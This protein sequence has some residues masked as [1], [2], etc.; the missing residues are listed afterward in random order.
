M[1]SLFLLWIV[2]HVYYFE[3][4]HIRCIES[5][6]QLSTIRIG[7][8]YMYMLMMDMDVPVANITSF[9]PKELCMWW[10]PVRQIYVRVF[11]RP[12]RSKCLNFL[13]PNKCACLLE[14]SILSFFT[15][16]FG[17]CFNVVVLFLFVN[18]IYSRADINMDKIVWQKPI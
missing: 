3:N 2:I 13:P 11:R 8:I 17:T 9:T 1:L 15:I 6:H 12:L 14:V 16:W 18:V 7:L 10:Y 4:T 5:P